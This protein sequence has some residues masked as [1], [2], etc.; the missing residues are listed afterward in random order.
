MAARIIRAHGAAELPTKLQT[1]LAHCY[2][3]LFCL[4]KASTPSET[5]PV[6]SPPHLLFAAVLAFAAAIGQ[7][8]R[9][10][11]CDSLAAPFFTAGRIAM[12]LRIFRLGLVLAVL[13]ANA[14]CCWCRPFGWWHG[15]RCCYLDP[16]HNAGAGATSRSVGT[17]A[18]FVPTGT[19]PQ[20]LGSLRA[21]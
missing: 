9:H 8:A 18:S 2:K 3:A 12:P 10:E 11:I 1:A 13:L 21:Y 4:T 17:P 16:A 14:G 7:P 6:K 15:H 5:P 19:A 20:N